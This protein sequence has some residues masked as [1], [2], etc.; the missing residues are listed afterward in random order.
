VGRF[1]SKDDFGV[2]FLTSFASDEAA[3][4]L[5]DAAREAEVAIWV[6]EPGKQHGRIVIAEEGQP[7]EILDLG[8]LYAVRF[9]PNA[10]FATFAIEDDAM[11]ALLDTALSE[12]RIVAFA[13]D[14][15]GRLLGAE[16]LDEDVE[17]FEEENEDAFEEG[18]EPISQADALALFKYLESKSTTEVNSSR[19][20]VPYL[21]PRDGCWGRAHSIY[22]DIKAE[23]HDSGKIW[24]YGSLRVRTAN[25]PR[26]RVGWGWH[27]AVTINLEGQ[28]RSVIDP[29]L[30]DRIVS[31]EDWLT[32]QNGRSRDTR[33][34]EGRV[35][36][37]KRNGRFWTDNT[38]RKTKRVL[39]TYRLILI[40]QAERKGWP[41]FAHCNT[42]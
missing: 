15:E 3:L 27:V 5:I 32:I 6:G 26:C 39:E 13:T 41:P 29:S 18:L 20:T 23:G 42:M 10:A 40:E 28:G 33:F 9:E 25:R 31:V 11:L 1:F 16:A 22:A 14:D 12:G 35:F 19:G 4:K 34:T 21:Y 37:R 17:L 30:F 7:V 2:D 38:M 36:Y 24:T 8:N